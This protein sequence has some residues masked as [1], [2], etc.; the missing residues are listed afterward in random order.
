MTP[1]QYLS[2][3][4]DDQI[5]WLSDKSGGNQR[6]FKWFRLTEICLGAGIP[7]LAAYSDTSVVI[8]LSV[9]VA[10]ALVAIIAGAL[11]LWKH[12]ELWIQYRATSEALKR[13]QMLFM[14]KTAPYDGDQAFAGFVARV[15]GLLGSENAAWTDQMRPQP[16]TPASD[17]SV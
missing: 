11:A 10:G 17:G 2:E 6:R 5:R 4:V 16:A 15:E 14:T 8:R 13:E 7:V 1:D 9:A 3:R 12:Q